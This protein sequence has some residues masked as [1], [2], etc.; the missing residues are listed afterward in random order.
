LLSL[1]ARQAL[2]SMSVFE[3]ATGGQAQLVYQ[4]SGLQELPF[5][6][7][8]DELITMS[9]VNYAGG[10]GTQ[11]YTLHQLTYRFILSDIVEEWE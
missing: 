8:M 10:L 9:L 3:P 7:A 6:R 4:A 1:T 5:Y 11:R 2:V